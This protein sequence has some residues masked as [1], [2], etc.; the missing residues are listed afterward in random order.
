M[1]L[2]NAFLWLRGQAGI[3]TFPSKLLKP[4]MLGLVFGILFAFSSLG[5]VLGPSAAGM[6]RYKTGSYETP[7][8]SYQ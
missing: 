7:F 4:Q 1:H 8:S 3:L 2:L 6:V 5:M